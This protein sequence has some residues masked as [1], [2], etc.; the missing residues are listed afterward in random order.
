MA[1]RKSAVF[2]Q[3]QHKLS[4]GLLGDQYF[5]STSVIISLLFLCNSSTLI[6]VF[7]YSFLPFGYH[8]NN[9]RRRQLFFYLPTETV[10]ITESNLIPVDVTRHLNFKEGWIVRFNKNIDFVILEFIFVCLARINIPNLNERRQRMKYFVQVFIYT[11][12][13]YNAEK[14]VCSF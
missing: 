13:I 7:F 9:Q 12:I 14:F 2:Y 1:S 3:M 10:T 8:Y 6:N 4:E 11:N 5:R